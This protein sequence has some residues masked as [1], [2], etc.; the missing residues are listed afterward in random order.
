M[1]ASCEDVLT[2]NIVNCSDISSE[3]QIENNQN[4]FHKYQNALN[5][6]DHSIGSGKPLDTEESNDA[7]DKPQADEEHDTQD[8]HVGNFD[9]HSS[10]V[11]EEIAQRPINKSAFIQEHNRLSNVE[12][13][14]MVNR[15]ESCN[16]YST[17][18]K[19]INEMV[20]DYK[21]DLG[22]L[23]GGLAQED[24]YHQGI[25]QGTDVVPGVNVEEENVDG[26]EVIFDM[27][28]GDT[29]S[30]ESDEDGSEQRFY[31]LERR[32]IVLDNLNNNMEG[33]DTENVLVEII[34]KE[35]PVDDDEGGLWPNG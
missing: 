10:K 22:D 15:D 34:V 32:E 23:N 35:E 13:D 6:T 24:T 3:L 11:S 25:K 4:L 12:N 30:D 2:R 26:N 28:N 29:K 17:E 18:L 9:S 14:V 27:V 7:L 33:I 31:D 19:D 16:V 21:S 8:H 1:K 5:N 20:S